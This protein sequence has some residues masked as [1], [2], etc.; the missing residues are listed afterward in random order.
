MAIALLFLEA[1]H[2]EATVHRAPTRSRREERLAVVRFA[3]L[4][5]AALSAIALPWTPQA[6]IWLAASYVVRMF[7]I[8]AGYHRYFSHRAFQLGRVPQ[9]LLAVLA[10]TSGQKGVLWWAAH[11]RHHHGHADRVDDVHSPLQRGFLWAH[12]GWV[13]SD[14]HVAYDTSKVRDLARFPELRWLDRYHWVP[15]VAYAAGT[16]VTGGATGFVWGYLV[17]TVL[18][19]HA[20]FAINSVAHVWGTRRFNTSDQSRN[21][22][23]LALI[24]MGEGWHN[25]HHFCMSSARQGYRWWEVDLTWI[26]LRALA[27]LGVVRGLRTFPPTM[28]R[29]A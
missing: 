11:H 18:L 17:A 27:L 15:T 26:G 12:V 22:W 9:F 19:Y 28:R 10:Q 2:H 5:L 29:H 7:G 8:T 6:G 24:T 25:N 20:T 13:V 23:W 4:H 3:A 1:M 16:W 14:Q 21:N